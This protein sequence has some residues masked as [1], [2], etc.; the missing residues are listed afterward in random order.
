[1]PNSDSQVP[2]ADPLL[3]PV[4]DPL[5]DSILDPITGLPEENPASD[6]KS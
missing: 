2:L 6:W 4:K 3:D 5:V 1:M